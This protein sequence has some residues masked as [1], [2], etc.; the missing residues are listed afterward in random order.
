MPR[1]WI[2]L[3]DASEGSYECDD[4]KQAMYQIVAHQCLYLRFKN[5]ATWYRLISLYRGEFQEALDL[6]GLRL[7][8]NEIQEYCFV[9][10]TVAKFLPVDRSETLFLL[11]L[12]HIYHHHA[13]A[14][15]RNPE[16]ETIVGI[17]ELMSAY[18]ALTGEELDK[19]A[20]VIKSLVRSARRYG[21]AREIP[22][23]DDG[24]YQ[25]FAIAILPAITEILSEHAVGR[26]GA[27]LKAGIFSH[28]EAA[29][30]GHSAETKDN[31]GEE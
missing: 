30:A 14:G 27:R 21:L 8:F 12:R 29:G 5:H 9:I 23:P 25:Q 24:D 20:T 26:V 28:S 17:P 6:M 10:P 18:E 1:N 15:D 11:V 3:A 19:K 16:D 13:M 31:Q 4:F 7:R 2:N 22:S